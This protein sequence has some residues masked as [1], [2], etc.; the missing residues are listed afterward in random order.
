[1]VLTVELGAMPSSKRDFQRKIKEAGTRAGLE[2]YAPDNLPVGRTWLV[3][4]EKIAFEYWEIWR[5]AKEGFTK[6]DENSDL[7]NGIR[8]QVDK[9]YLIMVEK[10]SKAVIGREYKPTLEKRG[11]HHNLSRIGCGNIFSGGGAPLQHGPIGEKGIHNKL[12]NFF[13]IHNGHLKEV[14]MRSCHE[15]SE[16]V[17]R[18]GMRAKA[19]AEI[20]KNTGGKMEVA[21]C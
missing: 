7:K 21:K 14:R 1:M 16:G 2:T 4:Q 3:F 10:S 17:R 12:A 9:L 19:Q 13:F 8:V 20:T 5:N 11:E 18:C 6:M 15:Q